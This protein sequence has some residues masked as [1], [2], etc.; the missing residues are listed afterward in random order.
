M[1]NRR[2]GKIQEA[3]LECLREHKGY[4]CRYS[5]WVWG[6]PHQTKKILERLVE[7]GE[8]VRVNSDNGVSYHA[9]GKNNV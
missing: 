9:K 2:L 4:S 1:T 7:L 3:V 6:T 5:N 8:A